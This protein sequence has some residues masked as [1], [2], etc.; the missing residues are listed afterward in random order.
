M[1]DEGGFQPSDVPLPERHRPSRAAARTGVGEADEPLASC[2]FEENRFAPAC[3]LTV[4]S[5]TRS[6]GPHGVAALVAMTR[7]LARDA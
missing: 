3:C 1:L 5:S 2:T 4:N 7:K 6:A